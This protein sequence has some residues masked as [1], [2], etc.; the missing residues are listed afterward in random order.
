MI[1][2]GR[3]KPS[4]EMGPKEEGQAKRALPTEDGKS[5]VLSRY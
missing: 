5:A 1:L 2:L 3:G 4:T